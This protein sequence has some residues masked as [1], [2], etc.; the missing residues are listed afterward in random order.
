[1]TANGV[2]FLFSSAGHAGGAMHIVVMHAVLLEN[3]KIEE[4][5]KED[6]ARL[7]KEKRITGRQKTAV[8]TV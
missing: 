4:R 3:L 7:K 6:I 2:I 1:L 8:D 5:H